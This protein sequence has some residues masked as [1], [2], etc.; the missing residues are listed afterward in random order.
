MFEM[1]INNPLDERIQYVEPLFDFKMIELKFK[2]AFY[3][4]DGDKTDR[5]EMKLE[6]L[7]I[8]YRNWMENYLK[9]ENGLIE[10]TIPKNGVYEI[11][12]QSRSCNQSYGEQNGPSMGVTVKLELDL[13]NVKDI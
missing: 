10:F 5:N 1:E 8:E 13:Q 11:I 12:Q 2:K 4:D 6:E 7:D 9:M 3:G